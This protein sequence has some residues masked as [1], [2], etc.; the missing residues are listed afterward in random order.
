M[1]KDF[2]RDNLLNFYYPANN[3]SN[4]NMFLSVED[5]R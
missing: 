4:E 1:I 2:L 3:P 5:D